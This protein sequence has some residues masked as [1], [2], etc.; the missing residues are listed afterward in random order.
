MAL[1]VRNAACAGRLRNR[2]GVEG[3]APRTVPETATL[4]EQRAS[5]G[6]VGAR[7]LRGRATA[8]RS[9]F[10]RPAPARASESERARNREWRTRGSVSD[11]LAGAGCGSGQAWLLRPFGSGA[12][13]TG[14]TMT[15]L[16]DQ[17]SGASPQ[18]IVMSGSG[19][20]RGFCDNETSIARGT[21]SSTAVPIEAPRRL[22]RCSAALLPAA[23]HWDFV[24]DSTSARGA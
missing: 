20:L 15:R 1:R 5:R 2:F 10:L 22:C 9:W 7:L 18:P 3:G 12:L 24:W 4:D 17:R 19:R 16:R 8:P 21:T 14:R 23:G 13:G 6:A 11:D